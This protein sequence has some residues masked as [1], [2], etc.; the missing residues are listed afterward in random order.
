MNSGSVANGKRICIVASIPF[1]LKMFMAP[2]IRALSKEHEITLV[3][4]GVSADLAGLTGDHV[5]FQTM[6]IERKISLWKDCTTLFFLWRF[7]K[8]NK[9]HCVH[10]ITPKAGLLSMLAARFAGVPLRLHTFTGQVW[11]TEKGLHR[12]LLKTLDKLMAGSATTVLADSA[13]QRLFLIKN[14]VV[15]PRE[16]TVL[17]DGSIAG[18]DV[19][20]FEYSAEMRAA[21]RKYHN[22]PAEDVVFLYLGRLNRSKGIPE[23]LRAFERATQ[24]LSNLH[25]IVAGPDEAYLAATV[26]ALA[27]RY[28]GKVHRVAYVNHPEQ[29]MSAA[30]VLCLPSHREGFGTVLIEAASIGIPAI[31][32]RIYGITDAV[33]DGVTGILHQPASDREIADA[34]TKLSIDTNLRH[35]MGKAARA[36]VVEKFSEARLTCALADFYRDMFSSCQVT[37]K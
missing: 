26:A 16:V 20:R 12:W 11:A 5:H 27:S 28:P 24:N 3:A 17:A 31:A 9:F 32:S 4:N 30:D 37:P 23:L 22:I 7:F 19:Q 36:R 15:A 2:H 1:S 8:K 13:S 14:D 25:L 34:M 10:S 6:P 35:Q 18:V 29:Y 33:E 21:I